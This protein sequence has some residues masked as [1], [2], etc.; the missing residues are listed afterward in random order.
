M[1]DWLRLFDKTSFF[2]KLIGETLVDILPFMIL[3]VTSLMMFGVPVAMLNLNRAEGD[4][5][6]VS[7]IFGFWI[8]DLLAN[9][10]FLSLGEF[11]TDNFEAGPQ[12]IL[13]YIFFFAATFI[14]QLTMLNMLIAIMGDSY[15]RVM[16]NAEINSTKTKLELM[17]DIS[18][19]IKKKDDAVPERDVFLYVVT[20]E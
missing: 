14:V 2:I 13:C 3:L 8:F 17:N 11:N 18:S 4:N 12:S 10:Y 6:I 16:E 19:L 1:F 5:D 20:P 9:Q 7:T 15:G